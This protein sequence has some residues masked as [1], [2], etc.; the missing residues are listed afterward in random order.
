MQEL[1]LRTDILN[2]YTKLDLAELRL[3]LKLR[4]LSTIGY[5][6]ELAF[7]LTDYDLSK[8]CT[9]RNVEQPLFPQPSP[10]PPP[11]MKTPH[12]FGDLPIDVI[13][14]ILD[15]LG[16]WELSK[17]VG[18]PTSLPCPSEWSTKSTPLDYLILSG[19][20]DK[21]REIPLSVPFTKLGAIVLIAFDMIGML[22]YL[23][24]VKT[25]RP[26]FHSCYGN[27]FSHIPEIASANNRPRILEWWYNQRD[28]TPKHYSADCI[29]VA[30]RNLSLDVLEWWDRKSR[31][32][33]AD[34]SLEYLPFPPR[35]TQKAL[36]AAS[37]KAHLAVLSFFASHGW[38]LNPGRSLDNASSAGHTN[39]LSWW[40]YESG[41]ELGK[42]VKYDK[43][44][45]YL[46]SCAGKIEV[47]QWWKEQSGK[48]KAGGG[49][50][51]QMLFDGDSLVGATRHNRPEVDIYDTLQ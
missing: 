3:F 16:S 33:M 36:E 12:I 39:V 1:D 45:V 31:A 23:W 21:V 51:A 34:P 38:P 4:S 2:A 19:S 29:D 42:D 10:T 46:A 15:H 18:V 37:S 24:G 48:S 49:T 20:P 32:S 6:H 44:A 13:T 27:G 30:C 5:H 14:E 26:T 43:N 9:D 28:I 35:Y 7:R 22:D 41:L 11:T 50:G 8:H 25:L 17:A 47:L 40:A